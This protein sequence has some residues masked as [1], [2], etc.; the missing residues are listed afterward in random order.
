[1]TKSPWQ[2]R[3]QRAQELASPHAFAAEILGFYIRIARFQEEL[4]RELRVVL[5]PPI[6]SIDRDLTPAELFELSSRFDSFVFMAEAYGPKLLAEVSRELRSRGPQFCAELLQSVWA[7]YAPADAQDLLAQA[8]LQPYAELLRSHAALRPRSTSYALCPFCNRK[9]G[10][11][12]LRQMGD[13]GAR[14]MVCT[15]CL[16]EW[17][18]RRIVCPGCGEEND[19]KLAV[20]TADDFDY[21]RVECCD[22]CKTYTKSIDLTKNGRAEPVVDELASA[23]LDLW[24]RERGYAKLRVNLLGL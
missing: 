12:V 1:M 22:S 23:P 14:S 9:P 8:F 3:I 24:A 5:Q 13:G 21:I 19:K 6:S 16:A 4:N 17:E 18:F 2:R 20:F 11:G 15:F 7:A 10:F